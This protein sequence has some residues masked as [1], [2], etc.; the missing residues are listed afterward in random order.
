MA[1][2]RLRVVVR[3]LDEFIDRLVKGIVLDVVA[4]LQAAPS[5]GGTP[6]D[7]GWARANWVAQIG[8]PY[9]AELGGGEVE[10]SEI[11]AA[12]ALSGA[13][14]A[15]IAAAYK[16]SQGAVFISNNVPYIVE[17]DMGSSAQA[18]AGFIERAIIKAVTIDVRR[19]FGGL[20]PSSGPPRRRPAKPRR[21]GSGPKRDKKT[22]RFVSKK[23]KR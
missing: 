15:G 13:T 18:A 1:S 6:V 9:R 17:L 3:S 8:S 20:S 22:G 14:L 23:R 12:A 16:T 5:E 21:R 10:T 7:T 19:N 2:R 4:N 11:Q